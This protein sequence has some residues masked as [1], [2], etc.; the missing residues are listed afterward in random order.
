MFGF[1]WRRADGAPSP[2]LLLHIHEL[3][4][5]PATSGGLTS[6]PRSLGHQWD[7]EKA[8][9]RSVAPG[10]PPTRSP[11]GKPSAQPLLL[12]DRRRWDAR[13]NA[14]AAASRHASSQAS[15]EVNICPVHTQTRSWGLKRA[16]TKPRNQTNY[17]GPCQEHGSDLWPLCGIVL[18]ESP[19]MQWDRQPNKHSK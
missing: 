1:Q 3:R 12:R 18:T 13:V 9:G 14:R 17:V 2:A 7:V 8:R 6:N 10:A 4:F 11:M 19:M 5:D 16:K 15:V